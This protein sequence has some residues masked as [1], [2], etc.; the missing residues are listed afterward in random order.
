MNIFNHFWQKFA[1]FWPNFSQKT[2]KS[3]FLASINAFF[4]VFGSFLPKNP[5]LVKN[6]KKLVIFGTIFGPPKN[7]PIWSV[8]GGKNLKMA[9]LGSFNTQFSCK[10]SQI[11]TFSR[12]NY[13]NRVHQPLKPIFNTSWTN[14]CPQCKKYMS[15]FFKCQNWGN[16]IFGRP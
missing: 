13:L 8:L 15:P 7:R 2:Q 14:I 11:G 10:K 4:G 16:Q 5:I 9:I 3:V 1:Y 12:S 6:L